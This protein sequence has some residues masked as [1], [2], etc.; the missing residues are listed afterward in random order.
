LLVWGEAKKSC[1]FFFLPTRIRITWI[2]STH[3]NTKR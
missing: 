2:T 1:S 3:K